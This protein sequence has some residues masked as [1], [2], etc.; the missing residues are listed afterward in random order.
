MFV[1]K[2]PENAVYIRGKLDGENAIKAPEYWKGL[3]NYDTISE[4]RIVYM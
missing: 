4:E 3:I 1:L 2:K